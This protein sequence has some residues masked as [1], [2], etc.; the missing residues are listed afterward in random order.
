MIPFSL[1]Q[2]EPGKYAYARATNNNQPPANPER[3]TCLPYFPFERDWLLQHFNSADR[4]GVVRR[5]FGAPPFAG[6]IPL[7]DYM[8][9]DTAKL[10]MSDLPRSASNVAAPVVT[11]MA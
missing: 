3:L 8:P 5:R 2:Y 9:I 7:V 1:L 10:E 6:Y 4:I 11:S